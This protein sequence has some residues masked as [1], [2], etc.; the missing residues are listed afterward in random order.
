MENELTRNPDELWTSYIARKLKSIGARYESFTFEES[1]SSSEKG[2]EMLFFAYNNGIPFDISLTLS[3]EFNRVREPDKLTSEKVTNLTRYSELSDMCKEFKE[4]IS[5]GADDLNNFFFDNTK[6]I[7]LE[8]GPCITN[9][10]ERLFF[11]KYLPNTNYNPEGVIEDILKYAKIELFLKNVNIDLISLSENLPNP[12]QKIV[13]IIESTKESH[14]EHTRKL[15]EILELTKTIKKRT[16]DHPIILKSDSSYLEDLY[17]QKINENMDNLRI[18]E[19]NNHKIPYV[20]VNSREISG[21][22]GRL[23]S[24]LFFVAKNLAQEDW[25]EK[26]IAYH[27]F[28]EA[29]TG[30][31]DK[32]RKL[33]LKLARYLG[34]E[35][36][37]LNWIKTIAHIK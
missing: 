35:K 21:S 14:K 36:E 3:R 8:Y 32:A 6:G 17:T 23:S 20:V 31:H 25:Q 27:E 34:K 24:N 11:G 13:D 1:L 37:Y 2:E 26:I 7:M 15:E 10:F 16:D 28:T 9:S 12:Q 4:S 18:L 5:V 33:E 22:T 19:F 29:K 30:S